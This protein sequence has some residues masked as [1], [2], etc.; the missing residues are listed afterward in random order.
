MLPPPSPI[1]MMMLLMLIMAA[2]CRGEQWFIITIIVVHIV[3][4]V[5]GRG[6][7]HREVIVHI[8]IAMVIRVKTRHLEIHLYRTTPQ[9]PAIQTG[10]ILFHRKECMREILRERDGGGEGERGGETWH[11]E[12][13]VVLEQTTGTY[14]TERIY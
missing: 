4:I 8:V 9:E 14:E 13:T 12:K 10:L 2:V 6:R 7:K 3:R 5:H 11:V 1:A